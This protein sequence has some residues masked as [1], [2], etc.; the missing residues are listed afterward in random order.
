MN[1]RHYVFSNIIVDIRPNIST[2]IYLHANTSAVFSSINF[3]ANTFVSTRPNGDLT[4][5]G[6][7]C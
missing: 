4:Q 7:I 5:I 3:D 1:N 2:G 6:E